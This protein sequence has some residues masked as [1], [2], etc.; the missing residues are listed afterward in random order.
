MRKRVLG[1]SLA[2]ALLAAIAVPFGG[3]STA[4]A[5]GELNPKLTVNPSAANPNAPTDVINDDGLPLGDGDASIIG[6][7]IAGLNIDGG[8]VVEIK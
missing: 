6:L 5:V 8:G 2:A 7:I 1:L 3:M 4:L